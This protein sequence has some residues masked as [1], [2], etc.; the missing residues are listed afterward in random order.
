MLKKT[1]RIY[2]IIL[3]F[4]FSSAIPSWANTRLYISVSI[5]GGALIG[6]VGYYFHVVYS[7]RVAKNSKEDE[8]KENNDTPPL[9]L[10]SSS[11]D[12]VVISSTDLPG[13][14]MK[15]HQQDR[16]QL[17]LFTYHW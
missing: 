1:V 10:K 8:Q 5:G 15:P 6:V 17:K 9:A 14:S 4:L 16:F 11:S 3:F 7:T 2:L 13:L 12:F